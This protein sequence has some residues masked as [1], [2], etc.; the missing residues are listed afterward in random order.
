MT[1][2]PTIPYLN[3]AAEFDEY[4]EQADLPVLVDFTASWCSPCKALAPTLDAIASETSDFTIVKVD[5]DENTEITEKFGV[6]GLPTL[7]LMEDGE[8]LIRVSGALPK[9]ELL[10]RVEPFV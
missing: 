2:T 9:A 8:E 6:Q 7:I 5:A 3:T 10:A 1:D 4:L